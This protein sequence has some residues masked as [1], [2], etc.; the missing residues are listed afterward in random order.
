MMSILLHSQH[1]HTFSKPYRNE[2]INKIISINTVSWSLVLW[3]GS[4]DRVQNLLSQPTRM[5]L[6]FTQ[7]LVGSGH[8][9]AGF[10]PFG[11]L[12]HSS[13][14]GRL[15]PSN[16]VAPTLYSKVPRPLGPYTPHPSLGI[17]LAPF[18]MAGTWGTDG[19]LHPSCPGTP[20]CKTEGVSK[21]IS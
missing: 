9:L 15:S 7:K 11:H 5:L 13:V 14:G 16:A 12:E 21:D 18:T 6:A 3:L 20:S 2:D 4:V 8:L 19:D 17:G 1:T 10:T